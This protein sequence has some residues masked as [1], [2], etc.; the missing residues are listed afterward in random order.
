MG[1][2][3]FEMNDAE[4]ILTNIKDNVDFAHCKLSLGLNGFCRNGYTASMVNEI[5]R[6]TTEH[7][8]K[9]LSGINMLLEAYGD[10][11]AD[12]NV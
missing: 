6:N 1:R 4:Q 12:S 8:E 10:Y 2:I 9:A 7:L 11:E 5:S 3:Y